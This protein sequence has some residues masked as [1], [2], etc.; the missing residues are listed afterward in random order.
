VTPMQRGRS[1]ARCARR[2]P[3]RRCSSFRRWQR[4]KRSSGTI[5]VYHHASYRCNRQAREN[6]HD[7]KRIKRCANSRIST[8]ILEIKVWEMIEETLLDPAQLRPC[9]KNEPRRDDQSIAREL[10]R[11]AKHIKGL[12][13]ERRRTSAC[14]PRRR[15]EGRS[16]LLQIAPSTKTLNG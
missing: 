9:I 10:A 13:D 8:H 2:P 16:T 11:I 4:V 7:R 12:D 15:W 14:M 3:R 5:S 1:M 6:V